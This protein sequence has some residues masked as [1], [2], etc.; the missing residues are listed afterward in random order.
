MSNG[1]EEVE[2]W[3]FQSSKDASA[4]V[5]NLAPISLHNFTRH[6][7]I[8]IIPSNH[9]SFFNKNPIQQSLESFQSKMSKLPTVLWGWICYP[10]Q[11][12]PSPWHVDVS[13][14]WLQHL[15]PTAVKPCYRG[16]SFLVA[17]DMGKMKDHI[18]T[19]VLLDVLIVSLLWAFFIRTTT[20]TTTSGY[21]KTIQNESKRCL[22]CQTCSCRDSTQPKF[23]IGVPVRIQGVPFWNPSS[24]Q[25]HETNR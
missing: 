6:L 16:C 23:C 22:A 20:T 13:N 21:S 15:E 19:N 12:V 3:R 24:P 25:T 11:V 8:E 4:F 17:D 2:W 9:D 1:Y 10:F 18:E 5:G 7:P 14:R